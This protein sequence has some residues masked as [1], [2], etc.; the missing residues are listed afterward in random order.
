VTAT[1]AS[2]NDGATASVER[3]RG[4]AGVRLTCGDLSAVFLP[5]L[6]MLGA[7]LTHHGAEVIALPGGLAAY[8]TGRVTGVPLL[9]P[10]ANRLAAR[11]YRAAGRSV[12][13]EGLPLPT[14]PNGLP[15]HGTMTARSGWRI[16]A[17]GSSESGASLRARF[18]YDQSEPD[19]FAAFP[20]PHRLAVGV[21]LTPGGLVVTVTLTAQKRAVPVSFGWH[22]YFRLP[23]LR[24]EAWDLRLPSSRHAELDVRGIPTGRWTP[25]RASR[26]PLDSRVFDDLFALQSDR[27]FELSGGGRRVR[28]RFDAAYPFA[29]IYAPPRSAFV[30]IEPMTAPTNALVAG[31]CPVISPGGRF[32]ASFRVA[33]EDT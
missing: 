18:D 9:A 31:G 8:R 30:A 23:G 25:A 17:V 6:G 20:Y 11:R 3:W 12:D 27:R 4:Q 29:Q 5:E 10:W 32:R 24:R 22:P 2:S 26:E 21:R 33:I 15:I 7:S 19:L 14:D 1:S 13:L 28:V 16:D